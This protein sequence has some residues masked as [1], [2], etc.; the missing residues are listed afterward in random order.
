MLFHGLK[1]LTM[2]IPRFHQIEGMKFSVG[3]PFSPN[4]LVQ[5]E[6]NLT[7]E[8]KPANQQMLMMGIGSQKPPFYTLTTHYHH[9]DLEKEQRVKFSLI[10]LLNSQGDLNA[11]FNKQFKNLVIKVQSQF[12]GSSK[13]NLTSTELSHRT[14]NAVQTFTHNQQATEYTIM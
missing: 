3:T 8:A 6:F 2:S 7:P 10:G 9:G 12:M 11:I 14:K 5:H 4:F 13:R 1:N